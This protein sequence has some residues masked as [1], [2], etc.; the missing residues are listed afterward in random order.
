MQLVKLVSDICFRL[1]SEFV[2][3]PKPI[4]CPEHLLKNI[5]QISLFPVNI[6]D[7]VINEPLD[8]IFITLGPGLEL[9]KPSPIKDVPLPGNVENFV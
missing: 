2:P 3:P 6:A 4:S 7:V 1:L 8:P 5:T 9:V